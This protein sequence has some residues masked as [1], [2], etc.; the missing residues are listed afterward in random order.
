MRYPSVEALVGA[1]P[2]LALDALAPGGRLLAK[3]ELANPGGSVKDRV[4]LA[5]LDRAE[6]QGL[7][8]PGAT[9]I[10]ATSGN[11]GIGLALA[12]ARRGYGC[13]IV[14]PDTMS[15]ER[16][17]LLAAY[18]AR[19]VLTPGALGMAGAVERAQSLAAELPGSLLADQFRNPAN[20]DV[21]YRTT[22]PEIWSDVQGHLDYFVAGVGTGGTLTGAGRYLKERCPDIRILAVEPAGSPLLSEGRTGPH[23]LQGLGA[24]FLP[25]LLDR[26]LID[27]VAAV[28]EAQAHEAARALA[29][30]EGILAG[31]SSGAALHAALE[32]AQAPENRTKRILVL[33]PDTGQRYLSTPLFP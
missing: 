10:E 6:E 19:V 32:L 20:V 22:G 9:V 7:L 23:G 12:C 4:A 29:R 2:T 33:L 21:H 16:R 5:I 15:P 14:M 8:A 24:N 1:T 13:A 27:A 18:G 30:T 28:T 11:T 25:P 26:S 31:V 17:R 3:L